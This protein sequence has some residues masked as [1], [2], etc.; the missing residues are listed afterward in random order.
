MIHEEKHLSP[1]SL[2]ILVG[3]IPVN[4]EKMY[5]YFGAWLFHQIL[6]LPFFVILLFKLDKYGYPVCTLHYIAKSN[7]KNIKF[8]FF[9]I[10]YVII[11][12]W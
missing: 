6:F 10:L 4:T 9:P 3:D 8:P 5:E 2:F 1:A 7:K 11:I 12:G